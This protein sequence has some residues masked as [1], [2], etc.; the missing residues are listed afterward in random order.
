MGFWRI[1]EF[2]WLIERFEPNFREGAFGGSPE[3]R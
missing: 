1:L 2:A 3:L